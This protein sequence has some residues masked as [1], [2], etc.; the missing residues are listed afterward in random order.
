MLDGR[1]LGNYP[2]ATADS[3]NLACNVPK[4]DVKYPEI[5][6]QVRTAEHNKGLSSKELKNLILRTR[7]AVLKGAVEQVKPPT[8]A[9]WVASQLL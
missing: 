7:C 9:S 1:V 8:M 2:L 6:R 5:T 4:Y 3:T